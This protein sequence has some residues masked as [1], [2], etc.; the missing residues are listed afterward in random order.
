[1]FIRK[2][3]IEGAWGPKVVLPHSVE[4]MVPN[5]HQVMELW[6]YS[7]PLRIN[8][9]LRPK[10]EDAE[11]EKGREDLGDELSLQKHLQS[12]CLNSL[13]ATEMNVLLIFLWFSLL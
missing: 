13:V 5:C 4:R 2:G 7:L 10:T 6:M 11:A 9:K 12:G 8:S 3:S 1:M